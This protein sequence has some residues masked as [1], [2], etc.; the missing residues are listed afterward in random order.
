MSEIIKS[1]RVCVTIGGDH[2]I[3]LGTVFGHAKSYVSD[4]NN[5]NVDDDTDNEASDMCVLWVDAH[6]DMNTPKTS[7]SGYIWACLKFNF[8][9]S[10]SSLIDVL[11]AAMELLG[12]AYKSK[13]VSS[14]AQNH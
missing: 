4:D 9:F 6:A 10:T 14:I 1:G 8:C 13:A 3:G 7:P 12:A 11:L 2:S 5:N